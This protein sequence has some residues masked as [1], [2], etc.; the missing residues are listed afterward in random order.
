MREVI[1]NWGCIEISVFIVEEESRKESW[2][3]ILYN[4]M[5]A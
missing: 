1:T 3:C 2:K 5:S 4:K